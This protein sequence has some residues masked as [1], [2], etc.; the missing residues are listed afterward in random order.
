[1]IDPPAA[2]KTDLLRA[3]RNH[4][5]QKILM[6]EV[7]Y[8]GDVPLLKSASRFGLMVIATMHG[9]VVR[10]V[11]ENPPPLPLLGIAID[12]KHG[13]LVK[14]AKACFDTAIEVHGKGKY[15]VHEHLDEVVQ[16]LLNGTDRPGVRVGNWPHPNAVRATG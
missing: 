15:L 10:D 3:I 12:E 7:G 8:N 13:R 16:D 1:M 11:L 6:D 14:R 9:K 4:G 2:G 5:P